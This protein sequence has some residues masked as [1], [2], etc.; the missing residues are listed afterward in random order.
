MM[1]ALKLSDVISNYLSE[2]RNIRRVSSHTLTSYKKD[3]SQFLQFANE[4]RKVN[5]LQNI[6]EKLIRNYIMFLNEEKEISTGSISRK[7]SALRGLLNFSIRHD[8]ISEN[9][10]LNIPNPKIK[11]KLPEIISV[12][13]YKELFEDIE[14]KEEPGNAIK[15]KTI[16]EL[17]YGCALRVS[18]VC[19]LNI[20]DI[21]FSRKTLKIFGKGSK[22]RIVPIGDLS[23]KIIKQY[24]KSLDTLNANEALFKTRTGKRIYPRIIYS[25][26]H[27]YLSDVTDINKKSPHI[28]RH[29]AA[30][31]MLDNGADLLAVKELLGHKN[32]STTQIY[33]HVSIERLKKTYKN[34]H[35]KS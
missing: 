32:L 33:T 26:V 17:L 4:K 1:T 14:K 35:P 21:D 16:F 6:S 9:P 28:L 18:E 5:Y 20:G 31:H 3:L 25:Y 22:T 10:A 8:L 34:S 7:L 29:S 24:I 27:N 2:L 23:M 30:T 19:S 12:N 13:D 15:I 11:R